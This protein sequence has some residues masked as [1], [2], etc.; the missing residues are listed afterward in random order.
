MVRFRKDGNGADNFIKENSLLSIYTPD[1]L[2]PGK[3]CIILS[4]MH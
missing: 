3:V 1:Q 4:Y 2:L